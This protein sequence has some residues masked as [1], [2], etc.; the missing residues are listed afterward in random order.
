MYTAISLVKHFND[1]S[2]QTQEFFVC[3][4]RHGSVFRPMDPG[5]SGLMAGD[6]TREHSPPMV[7]NF[8]PA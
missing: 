6:V 5:P 1:L 3:R 8:S 7:N 2:A 4:Q